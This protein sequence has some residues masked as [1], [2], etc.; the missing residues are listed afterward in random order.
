MSFGNRLSEERKRIGMNQTEFGTVGGVTKTSQLNYEAGTRSPN[1]DYWQAIAAIGVDVSYIL[2]GIRTGSS[3]LQEKQAYY[4]GAKPMRRSEDRQIIA[5][6]ALFEG[7]ND[8]QRKEIC[9]VVEEKKRLNHL[10]ET[11]SQLVRKIG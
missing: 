5:M 7:L 10:E 2:T 11:V 6:A 9:A 3:D 1:V 8:T 4:G